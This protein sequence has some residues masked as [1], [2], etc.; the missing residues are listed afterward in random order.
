MSRRA[1]INSSASSSRCHCSGDSSP[2]K[3]LSAMSRSACSRTTET[4]DSSCRTRGFFVLM[5]PGWQNATA[6]L[7]RM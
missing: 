5:N 4:T 3:G 1:S 7:T 6:D 2:Q